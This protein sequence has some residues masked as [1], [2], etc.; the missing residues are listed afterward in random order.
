MGP[1]KGA[2]ELISKAAAVTAVENNSGLP[3]VGG[4]KVGGGDEHPQGT[5]AGLPPRRGYQGCGVG[6]K[7][8][9]GG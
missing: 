4:D 8:K 3:G 6:D 2:K 9:R 5:V 1:E 7:V